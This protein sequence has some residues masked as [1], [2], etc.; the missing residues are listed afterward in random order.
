MEAEGNP[1]R[2]GVRA[3]DAVTAERLAREVHT[4]GRRA[5]R[6]RV[7]ATEGATLFL[8]DTRFRSLF[9]GS[10]TGWTSAGGRYD[11]SAVWEVKG[12]AIVGR[13]DDEGHGGLLYTTEEF[14]SFVI[15]LET[16][17]DHPFD[18]GLFLHM[19]PRE[20]GN[21]KGAQVTLDYRDGGEIAGIY[22]DG[23][24][25]H[26]PEVKEKFRA[27][28]N[29]LEVRCTG[30][31]FR[32]EVW[33]NGEKVTD[34]QL[35]PD[36]EGFASSG[37]IG[38]QVHGGNPGEKVAAFRSIRIRELPVFGEGEEHA[39]A[40]WEDL[41]NGKD[42][43]GWERAGVQE[44]YRARDGELLFPARGD[45]YLYTSEDFQD[46]RLRL[47]FQA[48]RMANSGVFLRAARDG[49]NPAYSGCEIQ[50]LDDFNWE[51]VTGSTLKPWQFTGSL[52]GAVAAGQS[53]LRPIGEWNTYEILYRGPRLAVALN[54]RVLYDVNTHE[55]EPAGGPPFAQR[56]SR[57]FIGLQ[58]HS[59]ADL[60]GE[61][62]IRFRNVQVQRL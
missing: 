24:L 1:L 14:S 4:L 51:A 36:A 45:G 35:P 55:L 37:R 38:L 22:S 3:P 11:G 27:G 21:L 25:M 23:W 28:W 19:R 61:T 44:G 29:H 17:I 33:L 5:G 56:A 18:S 15:E 20:D 50:I 57:G 8:E 52:Y 59:P 46:F 34:Y 42:L 49:S 58:A 16:K 41:F 40:G 9:D 39:R 10:L 48:A 30:F 6:A 53:G 12:S 13:T 32:I 54:G 60:E 2:V 31:E 62:S 7:E 43:T 26:N 47:D